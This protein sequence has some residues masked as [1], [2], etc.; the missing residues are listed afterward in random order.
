MIL[1]PVSDAGVTRVKLPQVD[2]PQ[3]YQGLYVYD[4]GEWAAIGYTAKE[5]ATLLESERY[6]DGKVYRIHR[7]Q[8]DG[9]MELSGVSA[10]RFEF[11]SGMFFSR[12]DR[13]AAER[14][15]D[16]LC[17]AAESEKPPCR[18]HAHLADQSRASPASPYVVGLVYPAEYEDDIAAWL[19]ACGYQGGDTVEG[20]ISHV[21]NFRESDCSILRRH[22]LWP[23]ST[24]PSRTR[25][26]VL[27]TVRRA[28][29]R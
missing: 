8:P 20:G 1:Y 5:V 29:Q 17:A 21:T 14:D 15:F 16:A 3:R 27:A 10:E 11:E 6:R 24:T 4:F 25:E 18:A 28:V 26:E 23:E 9:T 19:L 7:A 12:R 13:A 22:Q 2:E